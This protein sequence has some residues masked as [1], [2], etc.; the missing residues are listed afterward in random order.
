MNVALDR[1]ELNSRSSIRQ[2]R[3]SRA[4]PWDQGKMFDLQNYNSAVKEHGKNH[5]KHMNLLV[6]GGCGGNFKSVFSKHMS[7]MFI[8]ISW[9]Y[10]PISPL[11]DFTW[12]RHQMELFSTLLA[13]FVGNSPVTGEFPTRR[14]VMQNFGVFFDLRLNKRLS[15]Q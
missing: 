2:S 11:Q 10:H 15:K 5:T 7:W 13:F 14:P 6:P 9:I 3:Q 4:L 8:S 12:W 1:S